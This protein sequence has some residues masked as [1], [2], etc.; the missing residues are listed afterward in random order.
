[1][2]F[3]QLRSWSFLQRAQ[4]WNLKGIAV[5][6]HELTP[7][8][9]PEALWACAGVHTRVYMCLC[10]R[11]CA[12]TPFYCQQ[13]D[14][15]KLW[16]YLHHCISR[17]VN[18]LFY[19]APAPAYHPKHPSPSHGPWCA[20]PLAFSELACLFMLA[21]SPWGFLHSIGTRTMFV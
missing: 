7:A 2:A 14:T 17:S 10:V 8:L 13:S 12:H 21:E 9:S 6:R 4:S 15:G 20:I 16:P 1:M 11:M 3:L 5:E 18:K 19:S